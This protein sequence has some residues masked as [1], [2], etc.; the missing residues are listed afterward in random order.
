[1]SEGELIEIEQRALRLEDR[2]TDE[3]TCVSDTLGYRV[4]KDIER[5]AGIVRKIA[6][7]QPKLREVRESSLRDENL[8]GLSGVVPM[9]QEVEG[10]EN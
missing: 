10:E 6:L 1:M 2:S 4:A 5:L 3:D 8:A 9:K 7:A